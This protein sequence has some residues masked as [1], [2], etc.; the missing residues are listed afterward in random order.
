MFTSLVRSRSPTRSKASVSNALTLHQLEW[1]VCAVV[2]D[3]KNEMTYLE[4]SLYGLKTKKWHV[5]KFPFTWN[6]SFQ[7][8]WKGK[9]MKGNLPSLLKPNWIL[10]AHTDVWSSSNGFT[11][12]LLS[13]PMPVPSGFW[14]HGWRCT[15]CTN[16]AEW[17]AQSRLDC[18]L[19]L[20]HVWLWF[21][22]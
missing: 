12:M 19:G 16:P 11:S 22:V 9:G 2:A 15:R 10:N 14:G 4:I 3:W 17:F 21:W 20:G 13:G 8:E 6:I 5:W 7:S 18:A 1:W